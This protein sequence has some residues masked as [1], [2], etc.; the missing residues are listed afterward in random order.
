MEIQ[1]IYNLQAWADEEIVKRDLI[2]KYAALQQALQQNSQRANNQP[3]VPFNEQKKLLLEALNLV[4]IFG[5]SNPQLDVLKTI[6]IV[7][8]V[9]TE[10]ADD[11][12]IM[13][14]E[15]ASDLAYLAEQINKYQSELQQGL[16]KISAI[17]TSLEPIINNK[18]LVIPKDQILTR[19]TFQN[20]ASIN[21]INDLK[22]WTMRLYHITRGLS[23]ACNKPVEEI[24]VIGASNGS[25]IF[26]LVLGR[27]IASILTKTLKEIFQCMSEYQN[28]KVKSHEAELAAL[29]KDKFEQDYLEDKERCE[30]RMER[31]KQQVID[32]LFNNIKAEVPDYQ[33]TNDGELRKSVKDLVELISKGGDVDPVIPPVEKTEDETEDETEENTE[34]NGSLEDLRQDYIKLTELKHNIKI[35]HLSDFSDEDDEEENNDI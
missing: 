3:P 17:A 9:G 18:D 32:D 5:L 24:K 23:I 33:S 29:K 7:R 21:D 15:H 28:F 27:Y 10:A 22:I 26:S 30:E 35:E 12:K 4:N 19:V 14:T 11:I 13:M 16:Q 20:E 1:E 25:L 34:L 31:V 8:H 2:Q 6:N